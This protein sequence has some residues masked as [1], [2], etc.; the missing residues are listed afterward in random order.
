MVGMGDTKVTAWNMPRV[1]LD[2]V[3]ETAPLIARVAVAAYEINPKSSRLPPVPTPDELRFMVDENLTH[4]YFE[5]LKNLVGRN[6]SAD[7]GTYAVA[8]RVLL[9]VLESALSAEPINE[10]LVVRCCSFLEMAL[11]GEEIVAEG[12]DMM[13]AEN[14]G[15]EYTQRVRPYAGPLFVKALQ[16][17]KWID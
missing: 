11:A 4:P 15:T 1:L 6:F 9:P 17:W 7:F 8:G 12:V 14:F 2:V 13:V 16:S 10:D 5:A 3:P